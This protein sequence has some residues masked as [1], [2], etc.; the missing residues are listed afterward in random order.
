VSR[1]VLALLVFAACS[2]SA[3]EGRVVVAVSV[4][5][6]GAE[7]NP[8]GL[9]AIDFL[10][11]RVPGPMTHFVSAAY[12][13]KA[14][15]E[16][17]LAT[18]AEM[19]KPADELAIHLHAWSSLA[20]ASGLEARTSPSLMT[21][22]PE[23]E[24]YDGD[25]GYETDLDVYDIAELRALL[26][27]SRKLL[28]Q[29]KRPV[30]RSFRA[31]GFLGT[32]KMFAAIRSEGFTTD[33]SALDHRQIDLDDPAFGDRVAAIWPTV[34]AKT[35]PFMVGSV[36]EIPVSAFADFTDA[37]EVTKLIDDA[38]ARLA[39]APAKDQF[40]VLSF[41]LETAATL[42]GRIGEG[43]EKARAKHGDL[44]FVT[45]EQAGELARR[46]LGVPPP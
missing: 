39:A 19:L 11:K 20:K 15:P 40:I 45:L 42:A 18:L 7:L 2:R 3:E 4:D 25:T 22:G 44:V 9:D 13:T 12:F 10:R 5:W 31:G 43:V 1:W 27:T 34:D 24:D 35:Q 26:R 37:A 28:E 14:E 23:T 36:V 38:Y 17:V 30:S 29:T 46:G 32:P 6:E 8:D 41:N 33:S 16:P 21:G